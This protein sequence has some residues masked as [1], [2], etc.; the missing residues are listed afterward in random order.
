M[1]IDI[2]CLYKD[3]YYTNLMY[4]PMPDVLRT[5]A[6]EAGWQARAA[7]CRE[8]EVDLSTDAEVVAFSVYTQ[9]APATY[10]VCEQLR[11]AGKLVILGGP[12]FRGPSYEEAI[13]YCDAVAHTIC[14][15]QWQALLREIEDG[16]FDRAAEGEVRYIV[17]HGNRFRFPD[18]FFADFKSPSWWQIPAVPTS[19]GCPYDCEFCNAFMAGKYFLRDAEVV[20]GELAA[21]PRF[22]PVF[23]SDASFGLKKGYTLELMRALA[24]LERTLLVQSTLTRLQEPKLLDA[25]ALGGVKGVMVGIESFNTDLTKHGR[26]SVQDSVERMLDIAHE[27]GVAI[28]GNFICGLD[29]DGPESFDELY[30]FDLK[31]SIDMMVVDILA[32]H[33]NTRLYQKLVQEDRII[34]HDWEHYDCRHVVYRPKQMTE[35]QLIDR[36][37][38]LY[39]SITAPAASLRKLRGVFSIG[40]LSVQTAAIAGFYFGSRLDYR[41]KGLSLHSC[42]QQLGELL[43]THR[44][45]REPRAGEPVAGEAWCVAPE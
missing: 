21:M 18:G 20:A 39:Q 28:L 11:Q 26:G 29:T 9:C 10:R 45:N 44:Q 43:A 41:Q 30:E 23:L 5:W 2:Y 24:P 6:R 13:G 34:D 1:K 33:P 12:H 37:T 14:A 15:E 31:S 7:V 3:L 35:E 17:D 36:F 27:R 32:P 40:G 22:R 42:K 16:S 4:P 25:F 8:S 19:I 38:E